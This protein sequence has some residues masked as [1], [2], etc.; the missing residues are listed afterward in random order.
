[1]T[2]ARPPLGIL[3]LTVFGFS[4]LYAPQPLLP[5]LAEAFAR[6]PTEASLLIT[7]AMLPL[8]C[9]PLLY[10]YLLVSVPA[11]P[12]LAGAALLLALCQLGLALAASWWLM[13]TL[14]LLI[15]LC[16][17]ALFTALMTFVAAS[18]TAENL[19]QS[20]AWYI[21]ATILGGFAGRALSGLVASV[22][23][24]RVALGIWAPALLVMGLWT[25]RLPGHQESRFVRVT[26]RVFRV[27]M[28]RPGAPQA[29]LTVF[30]IFFIFAAVLNVLP[31][32]MA[33]QDPGTGTAGIGFAYL[34]Y[35]SGLLVSLNT[36]RLSRLFQS[37]GPLYA[38]GLG[39]Y[40]LGLG[41]FALSATVGVY[42][43]MFA[44][45]GG[46]FLIHTRL[47]GQINQ[48][49]GPFRGV[50]NGI[51]IAAYYVGGSLSSWLAVAIYC[52]L[53]WRPFLLAAA[54]V[55]VL[56]GLGLHGMLRLEPGTPRE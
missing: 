23:D 29:Y 55:L 47:S 19:R 7:L 39:L 4:T 5:V 17:P 13:L 6:G 27:V 16:L 36:G 28:E 15:G 41:L 50:V 43:A 51:Y 2:R 30:S 3:L 22:W 10:G 14:R 37:E 25:L 12:M 46:M 45:C 1:M 34:G 24:W 26:P 48:M 33:D 52:H 11:R 31:F 56:A 21:A 53:G 42:L 54:L 9:A 8:A 20:L 38:L 35:L 32:H 49:G 40:A 18:A 44:F